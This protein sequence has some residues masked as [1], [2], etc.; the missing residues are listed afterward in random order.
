MKKIIPFFL[1][2]TIIGTSITCGQGNRYNY[3]KKGPKFGYGIKAGVNVA[4]QSSSGENMDID[5]KNI[6]GINAGGYCNY[7]LTDYLAVQTE[8]LLSGKGAHWVDYYD[9]MKDR[10]TYIDIPFLIKYQP[11]MFINL[12]AGVQVGFRMAATQKDM[13]TRTRTD[14]RNYY[15]F[16]ESGIL[17]GVEANLPNR[18]NIAARVV[19]GLTSAT[20]N[21]EYINP[22]KN[23]L[24]Q[25][26]AGYRFSGR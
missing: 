22:W 3:R 8:L 5:V 19:F 10:V 18:I 1:L 12:H 24:I 23:N 26:T 21:Y 16:S 15:N 13:E 2:F 11:A 4:S 17:A 7:F 25:L 9:D 14:I 20:T 6:L